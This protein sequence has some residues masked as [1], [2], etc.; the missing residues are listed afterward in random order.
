[1]SQPRTRM[2]LLAGR[3]QLV[4]ARQGQQLL[5]EK[6]DALLREFHRDV[7][8]ILATLDELEAA[9]GTA[10]T[11]P[12]RGPRPPRARSGGGSRGRGGR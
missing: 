6:R 8:T 10:A 11:R 12:R 1:M 7:Q 4:L 3:A 5:E 9:A 2:A